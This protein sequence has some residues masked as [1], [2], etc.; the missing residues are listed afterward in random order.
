MLFVGPNDLASSMGYFAFDHAEFPEV[1]S[2]AARVRD[3]A[4]AQGKF[5]GH[6]CGSGKA[7]MYF[8]ASPRC[9]TPECINGFANARIISQPRK[10]SKRVTTSSI[11]EKTLSPC[12]PGSPP[13]WLH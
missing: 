7:G 4:T 9:R 1:Q 2:A 8:F 11:V 6:F 5:A 12:L 3:A 10:K 13:R